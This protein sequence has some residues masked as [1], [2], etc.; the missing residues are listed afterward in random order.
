[1]TT[2]TRPRV[3]GRFA[4]EPVEKRFRDRYY[5]DGNGCWVWTGSLTTSDPAVGYGRFNASGKLVQAHR[6]SYEHH[7]GPIPDG[8]VIDHLCRVRRCVNPAHLEPVTNAE[9]IRRGES[10]GIRFRREGTCK[11]GHPFDTV[12]SAGGFRCRTCQ[13]EFERR[14]EAQR[15]P[16]VRIRNRRKAK[17]DG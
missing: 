3:N 6:W 4:A 16:R 1:V 12:T 14:Y 2:S 9:N 11:R 8:L 5:V 10:P 13:R 15:P 17:N 7:V